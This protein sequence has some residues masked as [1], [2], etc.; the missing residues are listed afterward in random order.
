MPDIVS[1]I[2]EVIAEIAN[3]TDLLDTLPGM[4]NTVAINAG[5][6]NTDLDGWIAAG[7]FSALGRIDVGICHTVD[8][9]RVTQ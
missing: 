4:F 9:Y 1:R 2:I 8:L 6:E 7:D 5:I 3:K